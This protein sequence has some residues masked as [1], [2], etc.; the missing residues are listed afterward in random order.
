MVAPFAQAVEAME[1][2]THTTEPVETQF[3]WH[4]ILVE[5]RREN[6][7]PELEAVRSELSNL[8]NQRKVQAFIE[9]LR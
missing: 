3:G 6:E 1:V 7:P 9:S 5:D 2:G 8:I 4:V